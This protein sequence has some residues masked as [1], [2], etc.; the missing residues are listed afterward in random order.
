MTCDRI[1]FFEDPC[2]LFMSKARDSAF[3]GGIGHVFV[4]D[5]SLTACCR[6]SRFTF[7][8]SRRCLDR[9][10]FSSAVRGGGAATMETSLSSVA[11]MKVLAT[12]F[13]VLRGDCGEDASRDSAFDAFFGV[14]RGDDSVCLVATF[15]DLLF[16]LYF[17]FEPA[18]RHLRVSI[19][20]GLDTSA[21]F[22]RVLPR[23]M[24]SFSCQRK[25]LQQKTKLPTEIPKVLWRT[26][27]YYDAPKSTILFS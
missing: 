19:F 1:A 16:E 5:S 10:S 13:G 24:L 17:S 11:A 20:C 23:T 21:P 8:L 12:F 9:D 15:L 25:I 4:P 14:L 18:R 26:Q 7:C 6:S 3:V 22:A 2:T 27:K